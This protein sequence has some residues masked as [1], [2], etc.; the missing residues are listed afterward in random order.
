VD[1]CIQG[2]AKTLDQRDCANPCRGFGETGF[3][4]QMRGYGAI[5]DTEYLAHDGRLA[6]KQKTQWERYS[7]HSL[8][9]GLMR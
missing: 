6:G 8:A 2:A 5:D 7:K 1:V 4:G 3:A 9:H